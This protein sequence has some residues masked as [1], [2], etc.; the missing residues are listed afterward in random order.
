MFL[1]SAGL[2]YPSVSYAYD[3]KFR[4]DILT[5]YFENK[6]S[7]KDFSPALSY[8]SN[9]H[10]KLHQHIF[11][12]IE[13]VIANDLDYHIPLENHP[14]YLGMI[15]H[16]INLSELPYQTSNIEGKIVIF[17]G[18]NTYNYYKKGN[19]IF[20]LAL[21]IIA[22]KYADKIE[23]ITAKNLPY[24]DYITSFDKAH[25][26][27]DQIYAYDQGFNALEAMA[28]G[29][30]VFTG[31]EKEWLDYFKLKEDSVAINALPNA[32]YIAL[33]LETLITNPEKITEISINARK[34]VEQHHDHINCAKNYLKLWNSKSS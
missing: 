13:G 21:N 20:E 31:A 24:K 34:F 33:K 10:I 32:K 25:I 28:K 27:L 1:V 7:K 17:H 2:D 26:L 15:P 5:P 18:I 9:E 22:D 29:K 8:L 23:I 6:G 19:D 16:A 12:T 3:K 14:K 4:Y 11:K 30:V